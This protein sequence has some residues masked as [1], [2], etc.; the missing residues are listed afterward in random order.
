MAEAGEGILGGDGAEPDADRV[1]QRVRRAR[2]DRPE[3]RCEATDDQLDRVDVRRGRGQEP[4]LTARRRDRLPCLGML[5]DAQVIE[6]HDVPRSPCRHEVLRDPLREE[7]AI[8]RPF[9][10]DRGPDPGRTQRRKAG[11][12]RSVIARDRGHESRPAWR[13]TVRARQGRLGAGLIEEH[14]IGRREAGLLRL[15]GGPVVSVAFGG[16]QALFCASDPADPADQPLARRSPSR[17]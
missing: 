17:R 13:P 11:D 3:V 9:E 7:R 10:D 4:Q 5:V 8:Q 2:S 6:E 12:V 14:T 15:P 16:D 1:H